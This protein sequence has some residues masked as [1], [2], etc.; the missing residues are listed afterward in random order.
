MRKMSP[1]QNN[2][3]AVALSVGPKGICVRYSEVNKSLLSNE[4]SLECWN[5]KSCCVFSMFLIFLSI[6]LFLS[7]YMGNCLPFIDNPE[8]CNV[9]IKGYFQ[10]LSSQVFGSLSIL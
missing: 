5:M 1:R 4:K 10:N 3:K 2:F 6:D 9:Q 8:L 7:I